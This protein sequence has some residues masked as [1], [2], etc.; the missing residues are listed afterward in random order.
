[1]RRVLLIE[2][3]ALFRDRVAASLRRAGFEAH[4]ACDGESGW[5][6]LEQF[7]PHLILLDL[8]LPRLSGLALLR[9]MR[10]S[11][12]WNAVPVLVVSAHCHKAEE[13]VT[14]GAQGYLIKG[15]FAMTQLLDAVRMWTRA[16]PGPGA[17]AA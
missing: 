5:A 14:N 15:H 8:V 12:R 11:G 3:D 10:S 7:P 1:M 4:C 6:A 9:R 16:S 17:A 2:D 13:A